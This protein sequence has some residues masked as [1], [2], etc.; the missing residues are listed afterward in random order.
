MITPKN[1]AQHELMGLRVSIADSANP[2]LVGTSGVVADESRNTIT[3]EREGITKTVAKGENTFIFELPSGEKVM[4]N[5][6]LLVGRPEDRI[7]KRPKN[8]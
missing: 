6:E 4:I 2:Q 8:W 1:L 3:I 5:G 7:K